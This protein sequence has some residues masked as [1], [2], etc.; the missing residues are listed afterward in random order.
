MFISLNPELVLRL[1]SKFNFRNGMHTL[2]LPTK[3]GLNLIKYFYNFNLNLSRNLHSRGALL[4][5]ND[6]EFKYGE[7]SKLGASEYLDLSN[8]YFVSYSTY[9]YERQAQLELL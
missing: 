9:N 7:I 2:S 4:S 5:I 6:F 8:K 3:R 1:S